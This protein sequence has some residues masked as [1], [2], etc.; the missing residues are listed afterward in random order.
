MTDD[1]RIDDVLEFWF[2]EPSEDPAAR[3][4]RWFGRDPALDEQIRD[5]FGELI[6]HVAARALDAWKATPRGALARV[7]VLDQF[8]RNAYRDT[9]RA[10]V[11][12][13]RALAAVRDARERG[14]DA[15]LSSI[16]RTML[17]MPYMHSEDVEVQREGVAAFE[18][19]HAAAVAAGASPAEISG[20]ATAAD[21]ARR[22]AAIIERFGRFPHRNAILGRISTDDELAF[23]RE[24]GSSF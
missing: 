11:H 15:R 4:A 24:P 21:F 20:L 18:A 22:H 16:E 17:L 5:R 19:L 7:I 2:G 9:P 6:E 12:D 10:F 3:Q 13:H 1:E 23:L 8:P 14:H